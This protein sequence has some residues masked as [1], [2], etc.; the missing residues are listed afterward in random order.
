MPSLTER[1]KQ[2]LD[3]IRQQQAEGGTP[4]LRE[5]AGHFQFRSMNAAF[6]HVKALRR[7]GLIES[8]PRRARSLRLVGNAGD[9]HGKPAALMSVPIIG[10]I[11]AGLAA[12]C[13][14]EAE[15]GILIDVATFGIRAEA[16]TFALRV[17]GDSMTGRNICDGDLALIERDVTPRTGDVVAALIDGESTLKTYVVERGQPQLRAENPKF[18]NLIPAAELVIQGVMIG[19][20]RRMR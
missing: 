5:I 19:L 2:V 4:T 12:A 7:K 14:Q 15:G 1:Q 9:A 6:A 13:S 17:K 20:V 18:P 3:Y 10:S 16:R 8:L 11:P